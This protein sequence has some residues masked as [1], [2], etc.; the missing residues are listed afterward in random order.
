[1]LSREESIEKSVIKY[2]EKQKK[3]LEF[4][5]KISLGNLYLHK[6]K[7]PI[8]LIILQTSPR[9]INFLITMGIQEISPNIFKFAFTFWSGKEAFSKRIAKG[10]AGYRLINNPHVYINTN[11][12]KVIKAIPVEY[13]DNNN[14]T[15]AF[16]IIL[17]IISNII[18]NLE[19][20]KHIPQ[21]FY[22]R[23]T[24]LTDIHIEKLTR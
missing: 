2:R 7:I 17:N 20:Y 3:I 23:A 4:N 18:N 1:M 13:F 15:N 22:K 5:N 11:N 12:T 6:N 19:E 14:L 16:P 21:K 24:N 10:L 8:Y 9:V